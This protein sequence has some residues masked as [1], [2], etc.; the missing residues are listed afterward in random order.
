MSS[1]WVQDITDSADLRDL[2]YVP[3][4]AAMVGFVLAVPFYNSQYYTL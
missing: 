3:V 1:Q 4:L 2:K